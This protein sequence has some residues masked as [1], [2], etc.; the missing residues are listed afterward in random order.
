MTLVEFLEMVEAK[1]VGH[2]AC[3][4]GIDSNNRVIYDRD[5]VIKELMDNDG[6]SYEDALDWNDYNYDIG[7]DY[8]IFMTLS[9]DAE[10]EEE[11]IN[12][13]LSKNMAIISL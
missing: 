8:P 1:T 7:G 10:V 6:V 11:A 9:V 3:I 2:E 5:K 4:V 12:E 13:M